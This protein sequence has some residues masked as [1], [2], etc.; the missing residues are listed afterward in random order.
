MTEFI[1]TQNINF[2]IDRQKEPLITGITINPQGF[3]F[4][5]NC[6]MSGTLLFFN[7]GCGHFLG[8][9]HRLTIELITVDKE[10]DQNRIE[11][12]ETLYDAKVIFA[13][14]ENLVMS[15]DD[16]VPITKLKFK[17][18]ERLDTV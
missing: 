13:H 16:I 14:H 15:A 5:N 8:K 6:D 11:T 2:Y 10:K 3:E 18:L 1:R 9:E 7:R 12:I 17:V 4:N